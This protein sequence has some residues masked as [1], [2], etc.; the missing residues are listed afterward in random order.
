L[1][2]DDGIKALN[3]EVA[4]FDITKMRIKDKYTI[5][6]EDVPNGEKYYAIYSMK[7]NERI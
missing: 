3:W 2:C 6:L 4:G 1:Q 7:A 5:S